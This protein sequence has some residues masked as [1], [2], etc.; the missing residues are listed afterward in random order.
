VRKRTGRPKGYGT[1]L[2]PIGRRKRLWDIGKGVPDKYR[3]MC[4]NSLGDLSVII[5]RS[6]YEVPMK[7]L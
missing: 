7:S 2:V 3:A 6:P 1:A 4:P 5:R